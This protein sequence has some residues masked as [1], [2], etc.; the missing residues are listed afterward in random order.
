M[1]A[2]ETFLFII[3]ELGFFN[4]TPI[5]KTRKLLE[6]IWKNNYSSSLVEKLI[7]SLLGREASGPPMVH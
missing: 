3:T 5:K 2:G 7:R 6:S 4:Y 1:L